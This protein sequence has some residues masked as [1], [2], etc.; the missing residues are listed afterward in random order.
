MIIN[1]EIAILI[2][3]MLFCVV[4]LV[5]NQVAFK[6]QKRIIDAV[7]QYN[8][9]LIYDGRRHESEVDF[10]DIE[11]FYKTLFR[12]WDWSYKRILPADKLEII[13]PYLKGGED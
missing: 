7:Y 3:W 6:Q 4:M 5:K 13:E 11:T 12:L 10:D 8:L 1:I 2:V 9:N